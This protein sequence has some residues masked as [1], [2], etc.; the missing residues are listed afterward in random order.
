MAEAARKVLGPLEPI[1]WPQPPRNGVFDW[2]VRPPRIELKVGDRPLPEA[3]SEENSKLSA[4]AATMESSRFE[5]SPEDLQIY[6]R[7]RS[8]PTE[9]VTADHGSAS[10]R[11]DRED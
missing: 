6:R 7:P 11:L 3:D 8:V 4:N 10:T 1:A 9:R 2:G 5:P